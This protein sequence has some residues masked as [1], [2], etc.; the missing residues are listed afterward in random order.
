[1][2]VSSYAFAIQ[3]GGAPRVYGSAYTP[4]ALS[5]ASLPISQP[6]EQIPT[7]LNMLSYTRSNLASTDVVASWW[8]YGNWLSI[9]GNVTTLCDN[10]T[11]NGTQ[12][13]NVGYAMMANETQSILMLKSYDA[14]YVLVFVVE[15]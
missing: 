7:W 3:N 2:L 11:V 10:T 4:I 9:F 8:D 5:S 14:K 13:E 1:L 15:T 12:I 6:N